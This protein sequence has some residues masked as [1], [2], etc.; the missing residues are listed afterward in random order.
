MLANRFQ[1]VLNRYDNPIRT[2][3]EYS[4][5]ELDYAMKS[6]NKEEFKFTNFVKSDQSNQYKLLKEL[7]VDYK[8]GKNI[9]DKFEAYDIE[10]F[11]RN[12]KR[13]SDILSYNNMEKFNNNRISNI[14]KYQLKEGNNT[15]R[16]YIEKESANNNCVLKVRL[17]DLFH[18]AIPARHRGVSAE[19]M[20]NRLYNQHKC[21]KLSINK[22]KKM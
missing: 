1:H 18:L 12:T 9:L 20:T 4:K 7:Y 3:E 8:K 10:V 22:I 6:I 14:L 5:L 17:I 11:S 2:I 13:L 21:N 16:I 19:E 15:L